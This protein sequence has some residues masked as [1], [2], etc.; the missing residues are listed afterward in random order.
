MPN[1]LI[2]KMWVFFFLLKNNLYFHSQL[3]K[4]NTMIQVTHSNTS[5]LANHSHY[6]IVAGAYW[7]FQKAACNDWSL[8]VASV[9]AWEL[10]K[11][12]VCPEFNVSVCT[13]CY[14]RIFKML[15][16]HNKSL[17]VPSYSSP[18][19]QHLPFLIVLSPCSVFHHPSPQRKTKIPQTSQT[20]SANPF[21]SNT[22]EQ[23][24][25]ALMV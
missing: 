14:R 1:I 15:P 16:P 17:F 22:Q 13:M 7:Y 19:E 3:H 9:L 12:L 4:S 5:F 24:T 25:S 18:G 20:S 10:I 23:S 11:L 21:Q 6:K 8:C 2:F